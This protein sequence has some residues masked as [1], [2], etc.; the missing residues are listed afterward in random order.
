MTDKLNET[1]YTF[2][3][4]TL[5]FNYIF[6][7]DYDGNECVKDW[8]VSVEPTELNL[9]IIFSNIHKRTDTMGKTTGHILVE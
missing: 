7:L 3:D 6:L 4:K 5:T 8:E 2:N 1:R 9:F